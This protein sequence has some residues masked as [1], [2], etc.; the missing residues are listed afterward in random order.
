MDPDTRKPP[1]PSSP[2]P[3]DHCH[4]GPLDGRVGPAVATARTDGIKWAMGAAP[5]AAG[6]H[7]LHIPSTFNPSI[8]RTKKACLRTLPALT[9]RWPWHP[10]RPRPMPAFEGRRL[11]PFLLRTRPRCRG[12]RPQGLDRLTHV[13]LPHLWVVGGAVARLGG[14]N[15]PAGIKNGQLGR[16]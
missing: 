3:P 1:R 2:P 16:E 6:G 5:R 9:L 15:S 11:L 13:P 8:V 4:C 12:D 7:L 10:G 14:R